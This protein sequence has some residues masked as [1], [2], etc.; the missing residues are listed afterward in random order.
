MTHLRAV[1]LDVD[2]TL[3][4][5][6]NAHA[7]A[8]VAALA[9]QGYD[10]PFARVRRLIGM[11]G[12]KLL[13]QAAS[14]EKDSAIGQK[15]DQRR[16]AIFKERYLP[17]LHAFPRV[18]ALVERMQADGMQIGIASSAKAEELGALLDVAGVAD[19]TDHE[20]SS[21][22]AEESKPD[23]AIVQAA[24]DKLA[25]PLN[26]VVMIGDTPYDIEAAQR[27]GIAIIG[28]RCGGWND[29]GL[30]GAVAVYDDP[31]DLLAHYAQSPLGTDAASEN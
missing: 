12:D 31:A 26:Q 4:D 20:T 9:E 29:A 25:C 23:P 13:P 10:V 27:A 1:I 19:L 30:A 15:I 14:I 5:S 17:Q 2:G 24:L 21:S 16:Q 8:W 3:V 6:N 28:G 11:G 18:R 7:H 22:D